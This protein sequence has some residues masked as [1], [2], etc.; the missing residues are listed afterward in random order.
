MPPG[1]RMTAPLS[2]SG[3][4]PAYQGGTVAP[5]WRTRSSPQRSSPVAGSRQTTWHLG[6][7]A[8]TSLSVTRRHGARHAVI[9]LHRDR[10]GITPDLA[11][12]GQRQA[13]QGVLL[14]V[15]VVVHEIDAPVENG[16]AGVA[17]AHVNRPQLARFR[18]PAR[19]ARG[20]SFPVLM[21][22]R[23]G[24]RNCGQAPGQIRRLAIGADE[25]AGEDGVGIAAQFAARRLVGPRHAQRQRLVRRRAQTR[26]RAPPAPG[27]RALP[28]SASVV[29]ARP[30]LLH[31]FSIFV[32]GFEA[33]GR[34]S[35]RAQQKNRASQ[36]GGDRK[37]RGIS[38]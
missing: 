4:C 31:Q 22:S 32:A 3:H 17:F 12:V 16:R 5:Y 13:A 27:A 25:L 14:L 28:E 33:P 35:R 1:A 7:I 10:I 18:R 11:P 30:K 29:F 24:P 34:A 36:S 9:A 38:N 19:R 8:T 37:A 2:I 20:S 6:P 23:F 15:A 26:A 21:P